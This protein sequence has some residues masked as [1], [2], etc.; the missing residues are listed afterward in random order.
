MQL[1]IDGEDSPVPCSRLAGEGDMPER[2]LLQILRNLVT[3]GVLKSARGVDGGYML[4]RPAEQI[5]LLEI[6]EAID[7]PMT[8]AFPATDAIDATL[9]AH[10]ERVL[11]EL[12]DLSRQRL[13][14]VTVS[15][16]I[17]R[18]ATEEPVLAGDGAPRVIR[19]R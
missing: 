14:A 12:A 2:F 16:I 5:T 4:A 1:A 9:H 3:A 18:E 6:I 11:Q 10:V 13:Q 19:P 7:G 15:Q 17:D 8:A